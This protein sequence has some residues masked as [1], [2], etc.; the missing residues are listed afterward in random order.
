M[1]ELGHWK[2]G[3]EADSAA[4]TGITNLVGLIFFF[5]TLFKPCSVLKYTYGKIFT[6]G[7]FL[8]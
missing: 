7:A 6:L 8:S 5:L 4:F 2:Q 1:H 3:L